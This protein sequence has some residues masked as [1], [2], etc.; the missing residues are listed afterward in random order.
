MLVD[1][2]TLITP[3]LR[4]SD[5]VD[6][7][8]LCETA[9]LH[10][11]ERSIIKSAMVP[12]WR[13][14][15]AGNCHDM[16]GLGATGEEEIEV[17]VWHAADTDQMSHETARAKRTRN[18][19]LPFPDD[20]AFQPSRFVDKIE[21]GFREAYGLLM[22]NRS[23][24]LEAE[25]PLER[26]YRAPMRL[27]FRDTMLYF[28]V[29]KG[30]LQPN[31]VRAGIDRSIELAALN[32]ILCISQPRARHL[33]VVK[34]EL[35]SLER[36]DIPAFTLFPANRALNNG[37]NCVDP[38]YFA[39]PGAVRV[40]EKLGALSAE[41]CDD[42]CELIRATF[43]AKVLNE[44]ESASR[45]FASSPLSTGASFTARNSFLDPAVLIA[46]DLGRRAITG[47]DG[48]CTWIALSYKSLFR[49]YRVGQIGVGLFDGSAGVAIFLAALEKLGARG[50][51]IP[52]AQDVLKPVRRFLATV[53]EGNAWRRQHTGEMDAG[54]LIYP[55]LILRW[56][57]DDPSLSELARRSAQLMVK[58]VFA[59]DKH[60]DI[61]QGTAG[62]LV[63]L[64]ALHRAEPSAE[65]LAA[66]ICAGEQL[67]K[68]L[69]TNIA[70]RTLALNRL[71]NLTGDVR[72]RI[73][74]RER[75]MQDAWCKGPA[76]RGLSLLGASES[77]AKDQF[78]H[79]LGLTLDAAGRL[80]ET[81]ADSVYEGLF[82][83]VEFQLE[84]AR[85]TQHPKFW[86]IAQES[87]SRVTSAAGQGA[88]YR[89]FSR[90]P[91]RAYS[92]GFYQG[93]SGI[94][95]ELLRLHDPES[96]PSL[97]MWEVP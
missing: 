36:F 48:G 59:E 2:E 29:L 52:S 49:G 17:A 68:P 62:V 1:A 24:L 27:V 80:D 6:P 90:L 13:V 78:Q 39:S 73:E 61:F 8:A 30:S 87:A 4:V 12:D 60:F 15:N 65:T 26:L 21:A 10:K 66:A 56:L 70:G 72:F 69:Q 38:E 55:L 41:D 71:Y 67:I 34:A 63:G 18:L 92:P 53:L 25:S 82:G 5:V 3:P 88:Q 51:G 19:N 31:I 44:R 79:E 20:M 93:V 37:L 33:P 96:L 11:L 57:L 97:S 40:R 9:V 74:S 54:L 42:Q 7:A 43:Y 94:G 64:V 22:S 91:A 23:R 16:S 89:L 95:Y 76:G 85:R 46:K 58:K 81:N 32:R 35:S 83:I 47:S 77:S 75:L 45:T 86:Q 28:S 84:F 50:A 14:D